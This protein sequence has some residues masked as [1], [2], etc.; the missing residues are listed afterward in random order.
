MLNPSAR[1][2]NPRSFRSK[3]DNFNASFSMMGRRWGIGICAI[4][5]F[6]V[7]YACTP[8]WKQANQASQ[9]NA[10]VIELTLWQG[11]NP[12]PNREVFDR[13]VDQF[14]EAHPNIH[15][16]SI[17]AGQSEQQMPKVLTAVVG[18]VAP[19]ILW[20]SPTATGQFIN[21]NAIAPLDRWFTESLTV[22]ELDPALY[23]A[24]LESQHIWSVPMSTNN[25]GI[26]YR[27]SLFEAAGIETLPRTW[28]DLRETAKQLTEDTNDDG[29]TDRYGML[30]PLGKSEWTVFTWLPFL[31]SAG[32]DPSRNQRPDLSTKEARNA[33][34]L[35]TQ[36]LQ[37][38][39]AMLSQPERG[40]ELDD[41]L[42]GRVAMQL[43][44]PWTLEQLEATGVDYD[45]MPIPRDLEAATIVGGEHL[46]VMKSN[47]ER[48]A[49][50]AQF[51]EFALSEEFQTEWALGTGYL[52][53]NVKSRQSS[54]YQTYVESRPVLNVFLAQMKFAHAR[55]TFAG[56]SRLSDA[57]GR[58]IEQSLLGTPPH[59]A[60]RSA[61]ERVERFWD[62]S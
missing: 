47:P 16:K 60:L 46:F 43:T 17:Y 33:L 15:I 31:Y 42:A 53:V 45:V 2:K 26:F 25:I 23:D 34:N 11:I 12:P 35:W 4:V 29:Q 50:A 40:F 39:S 59:E 41:F 37:D 10:D 61:Q 36:L 7:C 5:T 30:L 19:D 9:S 56:Y 38:G 58:A 49:A 24:M 8:L 13:L 14:N 32:G 51:L 48:E 21:L 62:A 28:N 57:L 55:P 27:P 3:R 6:F 52:P 54:A 20:F 1:N 18:D 22:R 44:G